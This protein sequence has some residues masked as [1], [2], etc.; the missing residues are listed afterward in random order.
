MVND[1]TPY[2]YGD[3]DTKAIDDGPPP[4][5]SHG[6]DTVIVDGSAMSYRWYVAAERS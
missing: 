3:A 4:E 6:T 5:S 1:H 2:E